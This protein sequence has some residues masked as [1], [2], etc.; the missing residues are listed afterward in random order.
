MCQVYP[1]FKGLD[2]EENVS[3]LTKVNTLTV[4]EDNT[5]WTQ[6]TEP[7]SINQEDNPSLEEPTSL[8]QD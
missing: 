2:K 5:L 8:I 3:F 6:Q 7:E 1:K 4:H